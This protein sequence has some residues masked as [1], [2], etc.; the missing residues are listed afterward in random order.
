MTEGRGEGRTARRT[1]ATPATRVP[2]ADC[3][4][5]APTNHTIGGVQVE[6]GPE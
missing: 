6:V 1:V 3:L 5:A 2:A 4:M